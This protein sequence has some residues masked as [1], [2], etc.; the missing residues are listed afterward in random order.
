MEG[1]Q[2][3][4]VKNIY[5]HGK[6]GKFIEAGMKLFQ[7]LMYGGILFLLVTRRREYVEIEK[8]LLLI[9]VFGGFLFS[10]MWEAKT[11]YVLPYLFMQIPYMAMGVG[12]IVSWMEKAVMAEL[13]HKFSIFNR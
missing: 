12:E 1:E 2:L 5:E 13:S 6:L 4:L 10:L 11:R 7:M 9:A 3:P 8:Y